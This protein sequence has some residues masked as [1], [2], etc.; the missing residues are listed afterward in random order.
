MFGP[1]HYYGNTHVKSSE[2]CSSNTA[3]WTSL[4]CPSNGA[5]HVLSLFGKKSVNNIEIAR[6]ALGLEEHSSAARSSFLSS[7]GLPVMEG[8]VGYAKQS[9]VSLF[10][11]CCQRVSLL[12]AGT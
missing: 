6:T 9:C 11:G 10:L 5:F 8:V 1:L 12:R 3:A 2:I 7:F 4:K